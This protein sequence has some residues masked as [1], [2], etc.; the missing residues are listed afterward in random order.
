MKESGFVEDHPFAVDADIG[1][2]YKYFPDNPER[3]REII[4]GNRLYHALPAQM[5]DPWELQPHVRLDYSPDALANAQKHIVKRMR[6]DGR[7]KKEA[8][9]LRSWCGKTWQPTKHFK[10]S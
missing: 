4:L 5:D 8:E 3:L 2:L 6:E 10:Y 9:R 7:R 1:S